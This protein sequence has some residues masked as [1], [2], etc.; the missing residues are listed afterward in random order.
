MSEETLERSTQRLV[1]AKGE[2]VRVL[3]SG[4][5]LYFVQTV[6]DGETKEGWVP[7]SWLAERGFDDRIP[8]AES[9]ADLEG[10]LDI[11]LELSSEASEPE[12]QQLS[13]VNEGEVKL[14]A[15]W[16]TVNPL[17]DRFWNSSELLNTVSE[18]LLQ[19]EIRP[20]FHP[21]L[22]ARVCSS[23]ITAGN[24]EIL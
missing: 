7:G 23:P 12:L 6:K 18:G 1:I 16:N 19:T 10:G 22:L 9:R 17:T 2:Q 13:E 20:M 8:Q 4:R 14:D 24:L 11:S 21:I 3:R 5:D 15:S